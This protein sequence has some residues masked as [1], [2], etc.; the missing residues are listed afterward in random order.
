MASHLFYHRVE[1]NIKRRVQ[2][3]R[4]YLT[5][6]ASLLL[7]SYVDFNVVTHIIGDVSN[8]FTLSVVTSCPHLVSLDSRSSAKIDRD[9][10]LHLLR[11]KCPLLSSSR[12]RLGTSDYIRIESLGEGTFSRVF[13]VKHKETRCKAVLKKYEV[14]EGKMELQIKGQFNDFS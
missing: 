13:K 1:G 3:S 8:P 9:S 10:L 7:K 2:W 14:E 6:N 4:L 12:I 5:S 11:F